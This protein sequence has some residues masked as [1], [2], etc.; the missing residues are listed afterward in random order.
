MD[1]VGQLFVILYPDQES[2]TEVAIMSIMDSYYVGMTVG[3]AQVR[4]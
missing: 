4:R 1:K 2:M 3:V